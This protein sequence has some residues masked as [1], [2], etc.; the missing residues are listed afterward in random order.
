MFY[1]DNDQIL[2]FN[3]KVRDDLF[4]RSDFTG[5]HLNETGKQRLAANLQDGIR[6]AYSKN[7][8]RVEWKIAAP[9]RP[10]TP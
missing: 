6:E 3:G 10:Y 2:K 5:V 7:K 4:E 8:L 9:G 1:I